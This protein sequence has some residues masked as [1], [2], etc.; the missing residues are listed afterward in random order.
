MDV[1][2]I[3]RIEQKGTCIHWRKRT[4]RKTWIWMV[5]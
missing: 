1:E 4:T 2:Y 3:A 5:W